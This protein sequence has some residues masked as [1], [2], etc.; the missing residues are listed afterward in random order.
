[1]ELARRL[2]LS[3]PEEITVLAVEIEDDLTFGEECTSRVAE[4]IDPAARATL[5]LAMGEPMPQGVDVYGIGEPG[6][7]KEVEDV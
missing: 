4:A 5:A 3:L 1:M 7:S 6:E 2:N